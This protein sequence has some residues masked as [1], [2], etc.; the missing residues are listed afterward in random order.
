MA[1][2]LPPIEILG[3]AA[4]ACTTF[5][6]VPQAI[7]TIRTRDTRSISLGMQGLFW[8]GIVLWLIYGVILMSWPL[9]FANVVTLVLVTIVLVMKIRFG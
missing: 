6:W 3:F 5:A 7:K 9:I 2:S 4:A 1:F 8:L